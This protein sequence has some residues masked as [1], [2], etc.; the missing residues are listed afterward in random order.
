MQNLAFS[1]ASLLQVRV[2]FCDLQVK[3]RYFF[4]ASLDFKFLIFS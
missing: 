1:E 3:I 4:K 2:L